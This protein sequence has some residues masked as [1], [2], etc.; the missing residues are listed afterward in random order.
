MRDSLVAALRAIVGPD[1]VISDPG[2][3]AS[4]EVDWTGRFRGTAACVVRPASTAEVAAVVRACAA[5]RATIVTQGGNTGLVGGAVP[6]GSVLVSTLRL[7]SLGPVDELTGQVTVGA[8]ATL[9]DVQVHAAASGLATSVDLASRGSATIGGM[10]ATDA[11]GIHA[12]RYGPMR[13]AV[14][15]LEVVLA[16]GSVVGRLAGSGRDPLTAGIAGSEGTLGVVTRAR[17]SLI[18]AWPERAAVLVAFDDLAA[19]VAAVGPLRRRFAEL[20][21]LEVF[22]AACRALVTGRSGQHDPFGGRK[23]RGA[24]VLAEAAGNRPLLDELVDAVGDLAGVADA[25]AAADGPAR[26]RLWELREGIPEAIA[27]VGIPHKLDVGLPLDRLPAFVAELG[28]CVEAEDP[29]ARTYVFG[30][31]AVG[32]LHVNVVGPAPDDERVDDAVLRLVLAHGGSIAAEHGF[33]RAKAR[34]LRL[35]MTADELA[36]RARLKRA[37]DPAGL[38]NPSVLAPGN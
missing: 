22:D 18:P 10:I 28:A 33:G 17:L 30:H 37:F 15:G 21:A 23:V 34:W 12:L 1:H 32:N 4:Y 6:D 25:V 3:R 2:V 7:A 8:G 27:S 11:G 14:A 26:R 13:A 29:D 31:L 24:F 19:A 36:L 9:A 35:A 16:D 20:E 5:A 38:L